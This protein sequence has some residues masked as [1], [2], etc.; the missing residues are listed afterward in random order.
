MN[1]KSVV[2]NLRVD[3]LSGDNINWAMIINTQVSHLE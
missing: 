1:Y 3:V 2:C